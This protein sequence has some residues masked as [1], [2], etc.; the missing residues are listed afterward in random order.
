MNILTV[1]TGII[2][3]FLFLPTNGL[4][5]S[6]FGQ[7]RLLNASWCIEALLTVSFSVCP[8]GGGQVR[9]ESVKLDFKDNAKPKIRSLD[10]A[11]HTPGGGNIMV[12]QT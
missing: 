12:T 7:K 9:I 3:L 1:P 2:L 8:P 11:S 10:N 5:V 6:R 4:I